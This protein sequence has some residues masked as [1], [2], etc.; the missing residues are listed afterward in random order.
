MAKVKIMKNQA[1]LIIII[2]IVAIRTFW[3]SNQ[4]AHLFRL[5]SLWILSISLS[6]DGVISNDLI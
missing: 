5:M 1:E 3:L 4:Y 6:K 2:I